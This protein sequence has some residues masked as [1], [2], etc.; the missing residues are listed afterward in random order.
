[1]PKLDGET[2]IRPF[3]VEAG[4]AK[5]VPRRGCGAW[6]GMLWCEWFA[7]SKL[8]LL[9]I[10]AWLGCVWVLPLFAHPGWIL[11]FGLPYALVAGPAFG[12]SDVVE[13]CEEFSFALPATRAARYLARF[14][15]GG[16]AFLL[17]TLLDLL[18]LGLDL[19]QALA[20]LY[21]ETGLIKPLQVARPGLLYGLVLA[22]PFAV[23]AFSFTWSAVTQSRAQV[24]MA[25]FWG[26]LGALLAL[27]AGL[28]YEQLLWNKIN[29][30]LAC[31]LLLCLGAAAVAAGYLVYRRKE[32]GRQP[33]P[34]QLP[35]RWWA[36]TVLFL[37]GLALALFLVSWLLR[38]M[39]AFLAA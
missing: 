3:P 18:A 10:A 33:V 25:W 27:R 29:G 31:P 4:P 21:I 9:F 23:F 6:R 14:I 38:Q 15:A 22:F 17:F 13:G 39:P 1:M 8:L 32:V 28:Q 7:H 2:I 24:F 37:L 36:W 16:G 11:L 5:A 20:R 26:G 12:G 19:S 35:G 34:F 30:L